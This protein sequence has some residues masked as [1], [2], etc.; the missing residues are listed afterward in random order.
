MRVADTLVQAHRAADAR[1]GGHLSE[2][3]LPFD[4]ELLEVRPY[5]VYQI[6]DV[7]ARSCVIIGTSSGMVIPYRTCS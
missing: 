2:T 7:Y 6:G 4:R 1:K 5:G 3:A